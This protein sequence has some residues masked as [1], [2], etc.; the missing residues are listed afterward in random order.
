MVALQDVVDEALVIIRQGMNGQLD[1]GEEWF[2]GG[3]EGKKGSG[4][5]KCGAA[6]VAEN[7][8]NKVRRE[9]TREKDLGAAARVSRNE[10]AHAWEPERIEG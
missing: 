1:E 3:G 6:H 4:L 8:S 10:P 2:L 5:T 9:A 7:K